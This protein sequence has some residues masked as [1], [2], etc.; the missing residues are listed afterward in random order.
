MYFPYTAYRTSINS[1]EWDINK[2]NITMKGDIKTST[3]TSIEPSQEGLT[4]NASGALYEIEKQSLNISGVP[5]IKSAD[6]KII[7]DQGQV[8]IRR[9]A[10]MKTFYAKLEIDTL[11]S[12]HKLV[13]GNIRILSRNAFEGDAIYRFPNL[14]GDTLNLKIGNF[15]F[16]EIG[17]DDRKN[18]K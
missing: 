16:K 3:F 11:T 14:V 13:G 1:A 15:T 12:Y 2:K 6:A 18:K 5:F 7:P 8:S 17:A 4:F 9:D 10:E